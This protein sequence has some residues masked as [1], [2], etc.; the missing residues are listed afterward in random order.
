MAESLD[1]AE[2]CADILITIG[3]AR[4]TSGDLDGVE[5]VKRGL[6]FALA[7]NSLT[8]AMRAYH[9][10]SATLFQVDFRESAENLLE[11]RRLARRI[12]GD[13]AAAY[14]DSAWI[15]DVYWLGDWDEAVLLADDYIAQCEAGRSEYGED[16]VRDTRAMIRHARGD[17]DGAN[18][19]MARA[20]SFVRRMN[21]PQAWVSVFIHAALISLEQGR[22]D[23]ADAYATEVLA[24]PTHTFLN[25]QTVEL[26]TLTKA[27]GRAS[28]LRLFLEDFPR[29]TPWHQASLAILDGD[30]ARAADLLDEL[31]IVSLSAQA[32]LHAATAFA[33][34]GRQAEADAQL[35]PALEFFRS[36]G[37]TRY[38][39]QA[40]A[41]LAAAS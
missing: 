12:G 10:L 2:L 21:E 27:L 24:D 17:S 35:R 28:E 20:V 41:L 8:V 14:S 31:G 39:R 1:L 36:V 29:P 5:Q 23:E 32:R 9:N 25:L 34:S 16:A 30:Y 40:E 37:A 3:T 33:A 7:S 6:E 19:D 18:A 4:G 26:A 22:R 15:N 11:S 13:A 38:V